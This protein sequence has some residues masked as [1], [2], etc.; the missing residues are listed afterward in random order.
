MIYVIR[1]SWCI[2]DQGGNISIAALTGCCGHRCHLLYMSLN[3]ENASQVST[4]PGTDPRT[5]Q[6]VASRYTGCAI[7]TD[8]THKKNYKINK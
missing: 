3:Y 4:P 1:K 5:V 6:P 8:G 7:E 2:T